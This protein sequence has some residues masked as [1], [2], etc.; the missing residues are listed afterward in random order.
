M[1]W[2]YN[3]WCHQ[4]LLKERLPSIFGFSRSSLVNEANIL[5]SEN[6]F[7][8]EDGQQLYYTDNPAKNS[9]I[10]VTARLRPFS[11]HFKK[12][13]YIFQHLVNLQLEGAP[14]D[15]NSYDSYRNF[16][17]KD[18]CLGSDGLSWGSIKSC[19]KVEGIYLN[20][21]IYLSTTGNFD[22]AIKCQ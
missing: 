13:D 11:N 7:H 22:H 16:S 3:F 1:E 17:Y 15:L 10:L 21:H 6:S 8:I 4:F 20:Y 9:P 2:D 14:D 18:L 19:H 12:Y 5:L